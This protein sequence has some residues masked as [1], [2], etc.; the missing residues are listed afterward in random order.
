ML[1]FINVHI[2]FPPWRPIGDSDRSRFRRRRRPVLLRRAGSARGNVPAGVARHDDPRLHLPSFFPTIS[3][4]GK[5]AFFY[6][7]LHGTQPVR[8][9]RRCRTVACRWSSTVP[10]LSLFIPVRPAVDVPVT[11]I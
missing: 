2:T 11:V 10:S 8:M 5:I 9:K 4:A 3:E 6:W 7:D 1:I